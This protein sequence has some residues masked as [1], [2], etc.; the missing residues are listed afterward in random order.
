MLPGCLPHLL[1]AAKK[2]ILLKESRQN[3][4]DISRE[5]KD[6]RNMLKK[7]MHS[8]ERSYYIEL[9]KK[10]KQELKELGKL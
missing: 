10:R 3:C 8:A 1:N 2:Y 4:T 6:Y 9:F 7:I 5:K